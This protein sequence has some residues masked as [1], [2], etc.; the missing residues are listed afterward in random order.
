M[1]YEEIKIKYKKRFNDVYGSNR[2]SIERNTKALLNFLNKNSLTKNI[3]LELKTTTAYKEWSYDKKGSLGNV[4]LNLP[5]DDLELSGLIL[6]LLEKVSDSPS[7]I[8]SLLFGISFEKNVDLQFN[9]FHDLFTHKLEDYLD[10]CIEDSNLM[11]YYLNRYKVKTEWFHKKRLY[12]LY[13]EN[14]RKGEKL[15]TKDLREF[16]F[17][18]GIDYPFSEPETP[19]G[20]PDLIYGIGSDNPLALEIKIFNPEKSY[21]KSYI[22][23]GFR[24]AIKYAEDYDKNEGYLLIFNVSDKLI[25]VGSKNNQIMHF[26]HANKRIY[27][28]V[29]NLFDEGKSASQTK[30]L[31]ILSINKNDLTN[32]SN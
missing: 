13:C 18:Q 32:D 17:D 19:S 6:Q 27:I 8:K 1:N 12:E 22:A 3:I 21:G 7:E 29:V 28:I 20:R 5:V 15:L 2:N 11:L 24:Q 14:T 16:L 26:E 31:N 9:D 30:D 25:V 10:E 23:K 4:N